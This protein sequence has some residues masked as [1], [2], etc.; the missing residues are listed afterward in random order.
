MV[1]RHPQPQLEATIMDS[2]NYVLT[3]YF[4]LEMV[5]KLLGLGVR[6]Y[7]EDTMNVFDAIVVVVSLVEIGMT[8]NGSG[9][10]GLS[11]LRTFRLLRIFKLARSWKELN[12][13]INTIFKSL[14]SIAYL[15]LILLLI[16]FIFALLGMQLFGYRYYYC[17]P[18]PGAFKLCPE[19]DTD[20]P[21]F[22]LCPS[23]FRCYMS[24][25]PDQV[26]QWVHVSVLEDDATSQFF[27]QALCERK[28]FL[29]DAKHSPER[30][31]PPSTSQGNT[32]QVADHFV[33]L[34]GESD[35]MRHHFDDIY[36]SFIT[37]FQILTGE[38][39]NT[40]MYDGM[41]STGELAVVYFVLLVVVGNYIILNLFLAIL[42]DNFG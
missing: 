21:M 30:P 19:D 27:D 9:G 12:K 13:I 1:E 8:A 29:W 16:I 37:I 5:I 7:V 41:R 32:S 14:A 23:H 34:M 4:A 35:I 11:V 31:E 18:Y 28:T 38:N 22:E 6:K 33:A 40:V 10:S 20:T 15:S 2:I 24:C 25:S 42:L 26:D 17:D 39:W 36:I 3:A